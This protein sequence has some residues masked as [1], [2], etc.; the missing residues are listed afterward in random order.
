MLF[1][2]RGKLYILYKVR[3]YKVRQGMAGGGGGGRQLPL[4]YELASFFFLLVSS[5]VSHAR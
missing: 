3:K 2:L 4:L 5:E 1:P